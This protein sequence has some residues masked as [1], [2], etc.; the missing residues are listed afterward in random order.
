[1]LGVSVKGGTN[2]GRRLVK[3]RPPWTH[4]CT[5][6]AVGKVTLPGHVYSC[7]CGSRRPT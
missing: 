1:M 4:V 2:A 6:S 5:L 3:Q 7:L